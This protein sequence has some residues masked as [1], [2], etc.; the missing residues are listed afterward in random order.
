MVMFH[1]YVHTVEGH[2]IFYGYSTPFVHIVDSN[3]FHLHWNSDISPL[4]L[5]WSCSTIFFHTVA[6]HHILYRFS[7]PSVY[8]WHKPFTLP[9]QQ[10]YFTIWPNSS[11][12]LST[13]PLKWWC[14]T[15]MF[16]QLRDTI[17]SMVT[18]HHLYIWLTQTISASTETVISHHWTWNGC[19]LPFC[20]HSCKTPY[21]LQLQKT[22]C[23]YGW[24]KTFAVL[25]KQWY[26]TIGSNSS[27]K[28]ST[29]PLIWWCLTIMS[30]QW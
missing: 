16:I 2:H 1:H 30:T 29:F 26:F 12:K 4:D 13:V 14:L 15:I 10:W 25:L 19:V 23:V 11:H 28:L 17:S 5:K 22:I 8:S 24:H 27:Y 7:A 3:H 18:Q 21:P 6:G 20:P 9:L